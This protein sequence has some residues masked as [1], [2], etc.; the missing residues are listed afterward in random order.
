MG[1][2]EMSE[3]AKKGFLR[4]K[5]ASIKLF[6]LTALLAIPF[7]LYAAAK[8]GSQ[9]LTLA[10]LILMGLVMALTAKSG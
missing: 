3:K 6:C 5:P 9:G 7:G 10:G 4:A 2:G 1:V 8:S